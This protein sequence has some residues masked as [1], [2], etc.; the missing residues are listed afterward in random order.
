MSNFYKK[1]IKN[2]NYYGDLF[3]FRLF[4]YEENF[5]NKLNI[6]YEII[7]KIEDYFND[8]FKPNDFKIINEKNNILQLQSFN[9][10]LKFLDEDYNSFIR[11]ITL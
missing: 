11:K 3:T 7:S 9:K 6:Y 1:L 10:D 5:V 8:V 2:Y 4:H